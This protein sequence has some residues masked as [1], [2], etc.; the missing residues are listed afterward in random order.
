[1]N[2]LNR[3]GEVV[4]QVAVAALHGCLGSR[5]QDV[6]PPRFGDLGKDLACKGAEAALGTVA[7]DGIADFLRCRESD[8]NNCIAVGPIATLKQKPIRAL[9]TGG[10]C[11]QKIS[12]LA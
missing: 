5:D 1:M 6:I 8:A 12:A 7:L 4:L 9:P 11:A 3:P 10:C 2:N